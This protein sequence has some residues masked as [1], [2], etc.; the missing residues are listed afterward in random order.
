MEITISKDWNMAMGTELMALSVFIDLNVKIIN[1][2]SIRTLD[3]FNE[4][5]EIF[6]FNI[7]VKYSSDVIEGV[8]PKD[9]F[10]ILSPY[11]VKKRVLK[12]RNCIGMA[13]YS[14]NEIPFVYRDSKLPLTYPYNKFYS[15]DEYSKIFQL[16]KNA[17][18]DIITFDS[19]EVAKKE[20]AYLLENMCECVIGYE[21]GISHLCHMLDVPFIM[22]PWRN[23][24]DTIGGILEQ[25]LHLDM[26]TYFLKN[27]EEI[28]N[29]TVNDLNTQ[30]ENL[31]FK[32]GNNKILMDQVKLYYDENL[33][34]YIN[35][36]KKNFDIN[37]SE[38]QFLKRN[39]S[40]FTGGYIK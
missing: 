37:E 15:I 29:W 5:K 28:N 32:N 6:D 25:T 21:G 26:K 12:K 19:K 20:K 2:G 11:Y 16:I 14:D 13:C 7:D 36:K 27:I 18:Y 40:I 24:S 31:N 23:T 39:Y 4:Y 34:F 9:H 1:V 33:N 8:Y 3:S 38:K 22:L 35:G 17:G 30:I 10:K